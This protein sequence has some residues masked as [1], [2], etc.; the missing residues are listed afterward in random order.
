MGV[1]T[2]LYAA[3]VK[4]AEVVNQTNYYEQADDGKWDWDIFVYPNTSALAG[5]LALADTAT[6]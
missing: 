4:L 5:G 1:E 2:P 6:V 3:M